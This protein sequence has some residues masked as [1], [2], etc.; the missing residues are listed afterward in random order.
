MTEGIASMITLPKSET[1][2]QQITEIAEKLS[3]LLWW[4]SGAVAQKCCHLADHEPMLI[5]FHS[6]TRLAE[7]DSDRLPYKKQSLHFHLSAM[8]LMRSTIFVYP[9]VS[10][11][12]R[13]PPFTPCTFRATPDQNRYANL[14]EFSAYLCSGESRCLVPAAWALCYLEA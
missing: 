5:E 12:F 13:N 10:S 4:V 1:K 2:M 9:L 7:N 14:F 3:T 11:L 6:Y 8:N